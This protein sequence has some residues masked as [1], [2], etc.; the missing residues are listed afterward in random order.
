ML[1]KVIWA[2]IAVF[3]TWSLLDFLIHGLFLKSTYQATANLWR[4]EDEMK[5]GLMSFITF[6]F[7][8]CFVA[9]Y[10]YLIHPKSLSTGIRYGL[11]LG[12]ATGVSMGLGSYCYMPIPLSLAISWFAGSL[13]ELSIAGVI[14]GFLV[15]SSG[16]F[17]N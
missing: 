3:I 5:M 9:I 11:I 4:P 1:K 15:K 2:V 13:I 14:V 17:N 8:L 6:I 10:A 16:E 12:F 7:S